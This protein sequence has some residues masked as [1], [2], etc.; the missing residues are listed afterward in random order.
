[1]RATTRPRER[2]GSRCSPT[3]TCG[4]VGQLTADTEADAA[5]PEQRLDETEAGAAKAVSVVGPLPPDASP[6]PA[7][8]AMDWDVF[9]AIL[10]PRHR[11]LL[12]SW[13]TGTE[14]GRYAAPA[15]VRCRTVRV[16]RDYGLADR[17]EAPQYFAPVGSPAGSL[18]RPPGAA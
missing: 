1:M 4:S 10:E 16:V 6:A 12:L 9:D 11:L 8:S 14:A 3:I 2:A 13:K 15:G 7:S 5:L 17:R 18:A